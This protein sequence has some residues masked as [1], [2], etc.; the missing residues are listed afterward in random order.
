MGKLINGVVFSLLFCISTCFAQSA[1]VGSIF[2]SVA[3]VKNG[4]IYG[5][6]TFVQ[7]DKDSYYLLTNHHVTTTNNSVQLLCYKAGHESKYIPATVA[8]TVFVKDKALDISVLKISKSLITWH[9][10]VINFQLDDII[11]KEGD[12]VTSI[13]CP[14]AQWPEAFKGHINRVEQGV[15]YITPVVE[16]GRSGS[17]LFNEDGTK[18]IGLIAWSN[19]REGIA[20]TAQVIKN[21]LNGQQVDAAYHQ[22]YYLSDT[23]I[24]PCAYEI[25]GPNGCQNPNNR[26]QGGLFNKR[27][28]PH[29]GPGPNLNPDDQ[30][31]NDDPSDNQGPPQQGNK[32]KIF[33]TYPGEDDDNTPPQQNTQPVNPVVPNTT[34]AVPTAPSISQLDLDATNKKIDLT[35]TALSNETAQRESLVTDITTIK[36]QLVTLTQNISNLSTKLDN[37]DKNV[38][39]VSNSVTNNTVSPGKLDDLTK[40]LVTTT[41]LVDKLDLANQAAANLIQKSVTD[42]VNTTVAQQVKPLLDANSVQTQNSNALMA[43]GLEVLTTVIQNPGTQTWITTTFPT[44]GPALL[45]ILGFLYHKYTG[46]STGGTPSTPPLSQPKTATLA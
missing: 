33:P 46:R 7:E 15:Y 25:C 19:G 24:T 35:N 20:M 38:T 43:K 28:Q 4:N 8:W 34:P 42:T 32:L 6:A 18:A 12:T 26:P 45:L 2:E 39:E 31:N 13:G 40:T 1:G 14:E 22:P 3:K 41:S 11:Y 17:V 9:P 16:P 44:L 10:T 5:T 29:R 27:I 36:G 23:E 30:N 37:T 21:A